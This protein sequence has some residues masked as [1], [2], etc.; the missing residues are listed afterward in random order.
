MNI[1]YN[2]VTPYFTPCT[3]TYPPPPPQTATLW[4]MSVSS[5]SETADE[6]QHC[7]CPGEAENSSGCD[8][9]CMLAS[10]V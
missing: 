8:Y 7:S 2:N 10:Q 1:G 5:C 6:A 4:W 3:Y 9:K